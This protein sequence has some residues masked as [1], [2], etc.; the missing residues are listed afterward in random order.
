LP[1]YDYICKD[2]GKQKEV[3]AKMSE[4]EKDLKVQC[5][6]CGSDNMAQY[7]GNMKIRGF[8]PLH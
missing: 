7:F 4:K 2:C 6:S 1:V 5:D 8:H 3:K